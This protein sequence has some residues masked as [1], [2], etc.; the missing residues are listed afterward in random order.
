MNNPNLHMGPSIVQKPDAAVTANPATLPDGMPVDDNRP[1]EQDPFPFFGTFLVII[2][3]A[4]GWTI[5]NHASSP[6]LLSAMIPATINAIFAMG[7]GFLIRQNGWVSFGHAAFLGLPAYAVGYAFNTGVV[8]PETAIVG[9]VVATGILAFGIVTIIGRT[10]GIALS[11]LTLAIGQAFY[12]WSTK[13]RAVG[14]SDGLTVDMPSSV[15]GLSSGVFLTR[16]SMFVVC[17]AVLLAVIIILELISRSAFGKLTEAIRDNQERARFLGY[18]TLMPR[19]I[20]FVLSVLITAVAGVLSLLNNGFV[21]PDSLHWSA[22][23]MGL[24]MA[25]LGG[26]TR[27]WGPILGAITYVLL[28]DYV[29]DAMEHWLAI[30]GASLIAVIVAFPEGLSGLLLKTIARASSLAD[31]STRSKGK[32]A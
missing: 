14:G 4:V 13:S 29:G 31:R 15:F 32:S 6:V 20:I 17:W 9:A 30:V 22:S 24:I 28:Q 10:S 1:R 8:S 25:L 12:E 23:G 7:V 18:R 2:I 3:G 16:T 26:V 11:M 27:V 19:A 5:V 21:S